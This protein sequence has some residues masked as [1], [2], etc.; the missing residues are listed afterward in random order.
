LRQQAA[1]KGAAAFNA[2]P[3]VFDQKGRDMVAVTTADGKLHIFDGESLAAPVASV[4]AGVSGYAVGALASWVDATGGRWIL[5]PGSSGVE[6]F[7]FVDGAL[8]AGWKS[9]ALVNAGAPLVINGVAFL[10]G[11]GAPG[12]NAVLYALDAMS[13]QELWNSGATITSEVTSG[14][15]AA[16][17]GRVYVSGVDGT[18]YCFGFHLEI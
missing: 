6:A 8:K 13:G 18:Q 12:K 1:W 16:G 2:S 7:Q 3:T 10:L 9:R 14:G 5:V 11:K 15:M 4:A 17:G